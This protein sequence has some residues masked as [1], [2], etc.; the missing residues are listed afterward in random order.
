MIV[1]IDDAADAEEC[2]ALTALYDRYVG[3]SSAMDY[4]GHPLLFWRHLRDIA[5][6]RPLLAR[7]VRR[8]QGLLAAHAALALHP[9]S[10]VLAMVGPGGRLPLHADNSRQSDGGDWVPNHT[11]Q[12]DLSALYYLNNAFEG[13][14]IRFPQWGLMIK[15][16]RGLLIAFPSDA[17]HVHEVLPVR[18][19]QRYSLPIWFTHTASAGLEDLASAPRVRSTL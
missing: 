2:A 1:Q 18:R 4:T 16:R 5:P 17:R 10:V 9:E 14:E 12:R 8:A 15:P 7:L 11:P 13:G 19:G 6:A 3:S